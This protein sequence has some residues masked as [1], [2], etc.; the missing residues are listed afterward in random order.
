MRSNYW[1]KWKGIGILLVIFGHTIQG[2][3]FPSQ[4]N[5]WYAHL[6]LLQFINFIVAMFFALSGYFASSSAKDVN[7]DI[8]RYWYKRFVRILSPY[9]FWTFVFIALQ[10]PSELLSVKAI[11]KSILLGTG[12]QVGYYVIV[13]VQ[14]ILITPL[15]LRIERDSHHI[16][17]MIVLSCAGLL[18]NYYLRIFSD[19]AYA[20]YPY[21]TLPFFVWYPFYHLGIFV[22]KRQQRDQRSFSSHAFT[23]FMFYLLF[24]AAS[25]AEALFLTEQGLPGFAT[26]QM[27]ATNFAASIFIF[28]FAVALRKPT[29]P[30]SKQSLIAFFG[31]NSYAIYLMHLLFFPVV[32]PL[33]RNFSGMDCSAP[34][35]IFMKT[36]IVISLCSL[37]IVVARAITPVEVQNR[38]LGISGQ[39]PKINIDQ[40]API[41]AFLPDSWI[42]PKAK[43]HKQIST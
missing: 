35:C 43:R 28:L 8:K 12:V 34:I 16:I 17:V 32:E 2:Y 10:A 3:D 31:K 40:W 22:R 37:F 11:S 15:I 14:F 27:K 39:N 5:G 29:A 21:Y 30:S 38:L 36:A 6:V 26:S 9:L 13:L 1:D 7:L 41:R 25:I 19:S 24:V 20:C 23:Y 42:A 18:F 33:V 4:S